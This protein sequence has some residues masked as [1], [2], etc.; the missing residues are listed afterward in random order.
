MLELFSRTPDVMV[1]PEGSHLAPIPVE[2]EMVSLSA[3]LMDDGYYRFIHDG[4]V[5]SGDL[6]VV[7]A[8]HLIP[9]KARAWLDL[10]KRR[11]EGET[12]K[13]DDI[14]KHKNDVAR[15][16]QLLSPD[17]RIDLPAS[18]REDMVQFIE[19][20]EGGETIDLINLGLRNTT[21][22]EVLG[23]LRKIYKL[24]H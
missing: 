23:N 2:E 15:L 16:Y 1:P 12:V 11:N 3:I 13:G 14:K 10:T 4:K 21:I 9:L 22:E 8:G 20:I 17:L 6:P 24:D 7:G 5:E 18:I 19:R